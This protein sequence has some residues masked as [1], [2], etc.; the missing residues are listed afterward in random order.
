MS[1]YIEL[2]FSSIKVFSDDGTLDL[3]ELN[4]LLGVAL[5]DGEIDEDE[6]RVLKNIFSQVSEKD[7]SEKVWQ[8]METLRK[9]YSF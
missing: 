8:R 6:K 3:A 5:R 4:Y 2:T 9:A 7:V 1:D